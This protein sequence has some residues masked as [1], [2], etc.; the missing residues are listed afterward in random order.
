MS[1][2]DNKGKIYPLISKN[3]NGINSNADDP[4]FD[5]LK[6][7]ILDFKVIGANKGCYF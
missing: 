4:K 3:F 5:I 2:L 1:Y 6:K 7:A